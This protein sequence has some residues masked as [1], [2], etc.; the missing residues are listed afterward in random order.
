MSEYTKILILES[1]EEAQVMENALRERGIPHSIRSYHDSALDGLFQH[2]KGW[3]RLDAPEEYREE[4]KAIHRGLPGEPVYD[5][6]DA[7]VDQGAEG[8]E[9]TET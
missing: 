8:S 6:P 1:R 3:G 9:T 7:G 2:Q 4:I 5:E